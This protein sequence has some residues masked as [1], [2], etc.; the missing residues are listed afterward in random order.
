MKAVFDEDFLDY[1]PLFDLLGNN[2]QKQ[3]TK[4]VFQ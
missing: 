3:Q 1:F 4:I 2:Q